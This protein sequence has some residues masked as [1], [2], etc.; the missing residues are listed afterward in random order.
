M[1]KYYV[2]HSVMYNSYCV[3]E[4]AGGIVDKVIE[5]GLKDR[6]EAELMI[7]LLKEDEEL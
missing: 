2:R 1:D 7:E 5:T 6:E 4:T 3:Y